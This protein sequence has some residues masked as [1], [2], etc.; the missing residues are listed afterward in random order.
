MDLAEKGVQRSVRLFFNARAAA[1]LF[2]L[3][4]LAGLG[5]SLPGFELLPLLDDDA[6]EGPGASGLLPDVLARRVGSAHDHD[7]YV[8]G[9]RSCIEATLP[10]LVGLGVR[11]RNI[12][13]DVFT[14]A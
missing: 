12:Y 6:L 5:R 11:R 2:A 9:S 3:D 14:Q 8:A 7:A 13:F 10:A 4:Q 1:D